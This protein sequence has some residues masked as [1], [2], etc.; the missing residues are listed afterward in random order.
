[1]KNNLNLHLSKS[2]HCILDSCIMDQPSFWTIIFSKLY[3]NRIDLAPTR[4]WL[5]LESL[6]FSP[7]PCIVCKSTSSKLRL[8]LFVYSSQYTLGLD[9][10]YRLSWLY[11]QDSIVVLVSSILPSSWVLISKSPTNTMMKSAYA[12]QHT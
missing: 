11:Q 10:V 8:E 9:F 2:L 4:T 3:P 5:Q 7:P 12:V 1:M 6:H